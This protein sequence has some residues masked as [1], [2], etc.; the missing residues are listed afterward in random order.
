MDSP[1][2]SHHGISSILLVPQQSHCNVFSERKR[3]KPKLIYLFLV[4]IIEEQKK[5][6]ICSS[7]PHQPHPLPAR[8]RCLHITLGCCPASTTA[9]V[10]THAPAISTIPDA[11]RF[12]YKFWGNIYNPPWQRTQTRPAPTRPSCHLV[13]PPFP[14][15][16]VYLV[17]YPKVTLSWRCRLFQFRHKAIEAI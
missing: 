7:Y 15:L 16:S 1:G 3:K 4:R 14:K 6:P 8:L 12:V 9:K 13:S 5:M 17:Q 10:P 11:R 2:A